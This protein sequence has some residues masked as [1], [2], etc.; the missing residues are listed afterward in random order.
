MRVDV[1]FRSAFLWECEGSEKIRRSRQKK[2]NL[3]SSFLFWQS[4]FFLYFF[5]HTSK[6][7]GSPLEKTKSLERKRESLVAG[8]G[9]QTNETGPL[10]FHPS[11]FSLSH[12]QDGQKLLS[13]SSSWNSRLSVQRGCL[14]ARISSS[15]MY[16]PVS[17]KVFLLRARSSSRRSGFF[18]FFFSKE[19]EVEKRRFFFKA[20]AKNNQGDSFP[21]SSSSQSTRIGPFDHAGIKSTFNWPLH[22]REARNQ[23]RKRRRIEAFPLQARHALRSPPFS[24]LSRSLSLLLFSLHQ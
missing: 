24:F 5:T 15:V 17:S 18:C 4:F 14:K 19:V 8:G 22:P 11:P 20:L 3:P 2:I 9:E 23:A 6:G 1:E 7:Q 12:R 16:S 21:S 10:L 13:Q